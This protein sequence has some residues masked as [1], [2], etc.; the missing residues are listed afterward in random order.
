MTAIEQAPPAAVENHR[1][2]DAIDRKILAVLQ[3]DASLSVAIERAKN[4]LSAFPTTAKV[5]L[6]GGRAPKSGEKWA[7]PDL[8][9]TLQ[10][11]VEKIGFPLI[12]RPSFTLGG[13][14]SG[15][16]YNRDEFEEIVRWGIEF[17]KWGVEW[18]ERHLLRL[19]TQPVA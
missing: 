7:N 15:T 13:S 11:A 16:A 1:R 8:A 2:L 9:A 3:D 14:G 5:F 10:K 19:Q 17:N 4:R 6:P 12:I 18:C